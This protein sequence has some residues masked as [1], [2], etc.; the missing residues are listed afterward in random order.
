[1]WLLIRAYIWVVVLAVN[2]LAQI[3]LWAC[4]QKCSTA[5]GNIVTYYAVQLVA[6]VHPHQG[7]TTIRELD[8]FLVR[9]S[10]LVF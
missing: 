2:P 10:E 7:A 9:E 6:N 5:V 4:C 8:R 1:V 3:F